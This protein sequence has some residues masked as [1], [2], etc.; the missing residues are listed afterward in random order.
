MS[1]HLL[2]SSPDADD[3]VVGLLRTTADRALAQGVPTSAVRYLERALREPPSEA[4]RATVLAE[5]GR[6]EA[7]AGLPDAL[8]HLE[9]AID[10]ADEPRQRAALL[11]VY[12]RVLHRRGRPGDACE[13]FRRGRDE[14]GP[15]GGDLAVELAVGYL[16]SAMQTPDRAA[17][18]HRR[19][20]EI[21]AFDSPPGRAER[22]LTCRAMIMRLWV[23]APRREILALARR[24]ADG[25][26]TTRPGRGPGCT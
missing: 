1:A 23:G 8:A 25:G 19:A 2:E 22:A 10:L 20:D 3:A 5:L 21:V 26:R 11:L 14:L 13:A 17:E 16:S 7:A 4:L 24:L 15:D 12:G 18:A 9:A 6:A